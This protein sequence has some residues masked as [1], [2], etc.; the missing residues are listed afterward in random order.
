MVLS[1]PT[2]LK[3]SFVWLF[4]KHIFLSAGVETIQGMKIVTN[5]KHITQE[6]SRINLLCL[7]EWFMLLKWSFAVL[8]VAALLKSSNLETKW[9]YRSRELCVL[10]HWQLKR[11]I[12]VQRGCPLECEGHSTKPWSG[13]F[14]NRNRILQ[15]WRTFLRVDAQIVYKFPRNSFTC[16][17]EF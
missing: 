2:G 16:S 17:W 12:K 6:K 11:L 15:V 9:R 14:K 5:R 7:K 10:W 13:L 3:I 8:P 1:Y 4:T